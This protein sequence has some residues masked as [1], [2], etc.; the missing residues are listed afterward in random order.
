M[1]G[2]SAIHWIIVAVV[3]LIL[4]GGRGKLSGLLGD[5]GKGIRAFREGLKQGAEPEAPAETAATKV[6]APKDD[7]RS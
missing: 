2:M 4:F 1:G 3:V 7:A 6:E 5:A